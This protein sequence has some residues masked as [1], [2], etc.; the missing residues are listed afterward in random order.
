MIVKRP[1]ETSGLPGQSLRFAAH[2][3]RLH[4]FGPDGRA[5]PRLRGI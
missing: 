2:P 5:L 1:G 3:A 4:L